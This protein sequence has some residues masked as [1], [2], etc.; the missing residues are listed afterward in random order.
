MTRACAEGMALRPPEQS[1]QRLGFGW[2]QG[3]AGSDRSTVQSMR[4]PPVSSRYGCVLAYGDEDGGPLDQLK[5]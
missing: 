2:E 5:K 1:V 4:R 3:A